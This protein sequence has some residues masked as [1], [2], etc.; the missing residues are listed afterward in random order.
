MRTHYEVLGVDPG[1][2]VG[3]VRAAYLDKARELHPDRHAGRAAT[4][5]ARAERAMQDVNAAWAVLGDP[6]ARRR[7]DETLR[8]DA[9]AAAAARPVRYGRPAVVLDD[10]DDDLGDGDDHMGAPLPFLVRAGPV[11]LLLGVL[12]TIFVVTAFA[13]GSRYGDPRQYGTVGPPAPAVG[14]CVD[15][16]SIDV[17]EV[18]CDRPGAVRVETVVAAGEDCARGA[19]PVEWADERQ[20][21][22]RPP[23]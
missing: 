18:P 5:I 21:C 14:A 17:R 3:A 22:V 13:A 19:V 16:R 12:L 23:S 20:L 9:P 6:H 7:Y 8:P 15:V 1:A 10:P 4:E 2:S 11:V